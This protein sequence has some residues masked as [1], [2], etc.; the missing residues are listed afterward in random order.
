MGNNVF[1]RRNFPA[2]PLALLS[3]SV[4][5]CFVMVW[6]MS[7]RF[8]DQWLPIALTRRK[9]PDGGDVGQRRTPALPYRLGSVR[10]GSEHCEG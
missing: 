10:E 8:K 4:G 7:L 3:Q 9:A 1:R 6:S 5:A 2:H